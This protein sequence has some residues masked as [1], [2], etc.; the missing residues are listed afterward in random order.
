MVK[1]DAKFEPAGEITSQ[2]SDELPR[3]FID[4]ILMSLKYYVDEGD[5]HLQILSPEV[6]VQCKKKACLYFCPVGAYQEQDS[7]QVLIAYQSCIECG[8]CRLMCS[9]KNVGWKYPRGGF[10]I[11]YKFG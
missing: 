7:G 11:A 2:S 1:M 8:S 3:V 5:A 6:C 9:Y 10:G 4:D